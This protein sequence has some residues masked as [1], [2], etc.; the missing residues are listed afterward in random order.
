[1]CTTPA[2]QDAFACMSLRWFWFEGLIAHQ[3]VIHNLQGA[4]IATVGC[5]EEMIVELQMSVQHISYAA[6]ACGQL[7]STTSGPCLQSAGHWCLGL[8]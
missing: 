8:T 1:M 4:T 6:N 3:L 7:S 5:F 2:T